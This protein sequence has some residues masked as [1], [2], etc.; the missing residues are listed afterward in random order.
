MHADGPV[1]HEGPPLTFW[2]AGRLQADA[3]RCPVRIHDAIPGDQ[4]A[5]SLLQHLRPSLP[6]GA[7]LGLRPERVGGNLQVQDGTFTYTGAAQL[8]HACCL[9]VA[10][11][12]V[13]TSRPCTVA[14]L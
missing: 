14:R 13:D 2:G 7:T 3:V 8:M 11:A 12:Q 4:Q 9:T 5:P 6:V 1:I 10:C